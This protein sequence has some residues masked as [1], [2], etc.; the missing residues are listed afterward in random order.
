MKTGSPFLHKVSRLGTGETAGLES[1]AISPRQKLISN[2]LQTTFAGQNV[3]QTLGKE[4]FGL[5]QLAEVTNPRRRRRAGKH[6][7]QHIAQTGQGRC[8]AYSR[9]PSSTSGAA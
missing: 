6:L 4:A 9:P 1:G 8:G 2:S 5:Q 7:D 3:R